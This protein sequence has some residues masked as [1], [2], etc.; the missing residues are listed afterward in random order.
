MYN[1]TWY[2]FKKNRQ[3]F[4][5]LKVH[6]IFPLQKK[7]IQNFPLPI[8][9]QQITPFSEVRCWCWMSHE[10][11][12]WLVNRKWLAYKWG[13]L[14]WNNPLILTFYQHGTWDVIF[15]NWHQFLTFSRANT[16]G[17][18]GLGWNPLSRK[19]WLAC[20]FEAG[21]RAVT[22]TGNQNTWAFWKKGPSKR[23]VV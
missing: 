12:K 23:L 17:V 9:Q 14:G 22:L 19:E 2:G 3:H 20:D 16:D 13:I 21:T 8:S 4:L 18:V 10:V 5:L 6:H 15:P 1:T 7:T 11:S